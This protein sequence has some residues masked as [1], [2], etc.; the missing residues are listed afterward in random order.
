M[1]SLVL[2]MLLTNLKKKILFVVS[3]S[4]GQLQLY[5]SFVCMNFLSAVVN[6]IFAVLPCFLTLLPMSI[7]FAVPLEWKRKS[8]LSQ[9]SLV[10]HMLTSDMLELPAYLLS[11][12]TSKAASS[13]GPQHP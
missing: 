12:G 1:L 11:G 6:S 2:L 13:D 10:P 3:C 4:N 8:Q 9:T 5:L 7:D